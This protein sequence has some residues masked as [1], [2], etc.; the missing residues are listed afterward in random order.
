MTMLSFFSPLIMSMITSL[1]VRKALRVQNVE[2]LLDKIFQLRH[3]PDHH[4]RPH[5]LEQCALIY[6]VINVF[7]LNSA[8]RSF[9]THVLLAV[10]IVRGTFT[11]IR[12]KIIE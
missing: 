10:G 3:F 8:I 1:L 11:A 5:S 6:S 9:T 12:M 4:E 2:T 7:L